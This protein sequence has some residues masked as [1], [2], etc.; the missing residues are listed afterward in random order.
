MLKK[1]AHAM[2]P[3]FGCLIEVLKRG[4]LH[5]DSDYYGILELMVCAVVVLL[6]IWKGNTLL[7]II[8]GTTVY[9]IA[10]RLMGGM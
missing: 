6:H 4:N 3:L 10:I 9:M 8:S 1:R 5:R 2:S 7:S